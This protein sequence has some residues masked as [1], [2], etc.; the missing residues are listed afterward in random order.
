MYKNTVF[1]MMIGLFLLAFVSMPC[2]VA[3]DDDTVSVIDQRGKSVT[4]PKNIDRIVVIPKP[5]ASLIFTIDGTE[6]RIVGM[7]PDVKSL[8]EK[9]NVLANI[10]PGLKDVSTNFVKSGFEPNVEE[11]LKLE[12][13]VIIQWGD[14][15]DDIIAPLEATGIPTVGIVFGNFENTTMLYGKILGKE[16]QAAK[17]IDY[18]HNL[19]QE[20]MSTT[21]QISDQ[22]KPRVLTLYLGNQDQFS[23][24]GFDWIELSG[25]I[26]V[27]DELSIYGDSANMEQVIAWNPDIIYI[28]PSATFTPEQVLSNDIEGQDWSSINAAKNGNIY[29]VPEGVH[30]WGPPNQEIPLMWEWLVEIQHPELLDYDVRLDLVDFYLEYYDYHLSDEEIDVILRCDMNQ[31]LPCCCA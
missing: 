25:G 20:I 7:H 22:D 8:I 24:I 15:G 5:A 14:R 18:H 31:G 2:C 19:R 23:I 29:A 11:I 17:L 9:D 3:N 27:A 26:N 12:P 4:I 6:E 10:A 16:E 21:S 1:Y 13:D 28:F 30:W